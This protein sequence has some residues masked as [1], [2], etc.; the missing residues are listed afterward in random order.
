MAPFRNHAYA[1]R[2]QIRPVV[3]YIRR[4]A[5]IGFVMQDWWRRARTG[6]K[7]AP[8]TGEMPVEWNGKHT[9]WMA[10]TGENPVPGY[11]ELCLESVRRHNTE[12]CN[13]VVIT[14]SNLHEYFPEL[15]PA[16]P[17]LSY[18][19]RSD[20][21]RCRALHLYGGMYLDM[22]TICFRPLHQWWSVL[23]KYDF[24]G[25]DG[26]PSS[27]LFG[28]G[29]LGPARRKSNLTT[30][31]EAELHRVLDRRYADLVAFRET[32]NDLSKDCLGWTEILGD[33]VEQIS[34]TLAEKHRLSLKRISRRYFSLSADLFTNAEL[35]EQAMLRVSPNTYL[36]TMNNEMYPNELKRRT[37]HE[38]STLDWGIVSLLRQALGA[39]LPP[40]ET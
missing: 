26:R 29:V 35:F 34:I 31:W 19:H 11:L 16:Y 33:L 17:F 15:H 3:N 12:M 9:I 5:A 23:E 10:W 2:R 36:V 38:V 28:M 32:N 21:L 37:R 4:P 6:F 8:L 13:V 25:Y 27:Q 18:V 30:A 1:F 20:Y 39:S 7:S 22:D 24:A 40:L 14:P